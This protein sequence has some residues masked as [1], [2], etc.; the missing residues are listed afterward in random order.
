MRSVD[1]ESLVDGLDDKNNGI[2]GCKSCEAEP[3]VVAA[4]INNLTGFG[5]AFAGLHANIYKLQDN[6]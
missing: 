2:S 4:P 6:P 1:G 3:Q 5:R